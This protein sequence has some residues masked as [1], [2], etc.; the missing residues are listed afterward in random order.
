MHSGLRR[1]VVVVA[2]LNLAYFGVE[3][4]VA[5]AIGSVSLFA[6]SIDFLEDASINLLIAVAL[7]WSALRRARVGMALAGILLVPGVATLW[8]AWNKLLQPLPPA[9]LALSLTGGGALL[10][11]LS[12][13]L[14]LARH[15]ASGGSL[16]RAAFLSARNDTVANV[17]II[18]AG[19][20]TAWLHSAWPDLLVGLA[21]AAMNADAAR[22]VWSAARAEHRE[23]GASI[24]P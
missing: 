10:V 8:T 5:L 19:L 11:N 1:V 21:I 7:G 2:I 18:A 22:E 24:P 23:A 15:R 14:L 6:D 12:C 17:A 4:A 9:P 3:F 20:L 13:A 16:T